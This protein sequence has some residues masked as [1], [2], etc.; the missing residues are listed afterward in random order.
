MEAFIDDIADRYRIHAFG[1]IRRMGAASSS[2]QFMDVS[3]KQWMLKTGRPDSRT[4]TILQSFSLLFPPFRYPEPI[5]QVDDPYLLYPYM[6]GA[7]LE[8]GLFENPEVAGQVLEAIDRLP[9]LMRSLA[10]IPQLEQAL[11][12]GN[13]DFSPS[14]NREASAP[15]ALANTGELFPNHHQRMD[16]DRSFQWTKDRANACCD[17]VRTS[18]MWSETLLETFNVYAQSMQSIHYAIAGNNLSHTALVP[19]HLLLDDNTTLCILGWHIAP[20]PRFFMMYSYLAWEA[21]HSSKPDPFVDF[22]ARLLENRSRPFYDQRLLVAAF[23]LIDQVERCSQDASHTTSQAWVEK[24]RPAEQ[25]FRDCV[26]RL[27][28]LKLNSQEKDLG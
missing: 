9:V 12:S 10:L 4:F 2:W 3:G 20:R 18:G 24:M 15:R 27:D 11:R 6:D 23:C 14:K 1:P 28:R 19:E 25:A 13:G 7:P 8:Q 22:R 21:L 16:I 26:E 5:S 17:L